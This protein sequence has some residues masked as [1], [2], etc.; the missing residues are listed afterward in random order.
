M[1][2][3]RRKIGVRGDKRRRGKTKSERDC[4]IMVNVQE[5]RRKAGSEEGNQVKEEEEGKKSEEE[6]EKNCKREE[7][8]ERTEE[9]QNGSNRE[10]ENR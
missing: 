2:T 9:K 5:A 8:K 6:K 7:H 1:R 3:R 4:D 10:D